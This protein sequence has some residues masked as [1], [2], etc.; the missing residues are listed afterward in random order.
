MRYPQILS[1]YFDTL[2]HEILINL[3]RKNVKDGTSGAVDQALSEKW[4]NGEWSG[5][6]NR[7]RLATRRKSIP[8]TSEYISQ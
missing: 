1:K 6:G 2:N 4:S 5:H 8:I 3:L 7:G